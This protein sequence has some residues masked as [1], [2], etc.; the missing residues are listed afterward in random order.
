MRVQGTIANIRATHPE[1]GNLEIAR[2]EQHIGV[3]MLAF[4]LKTG[5]G[6]ENEC[7]GDILVIEALQR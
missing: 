6:T 7:D 1:V 5:G 4:F 2:K 3:V